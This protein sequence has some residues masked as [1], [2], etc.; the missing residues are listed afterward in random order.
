MGQ[1]ARDVIL[2][3]KGVADLNYKL[4]GPLL[5]LMQRRSNPVRFTIWS[6]VVYFL[7]PYALFAL[8]WRGMRYPAYW[9]RWPERFG[10]ISPMRYEKTM[11]VHAV[12]VGEVRGI[13]EL[14]KSLARKYPSHRILVT[15][16]TPTGSSQV[17]E[18]FGDQVS[19]SYVPYDLPRAV[20]RFMDRVNPDFVV[21]A[22]TEFWPNLFGECRR[23]NIPLLLV[24]VRVSAASIRG[25]RRVPRTSHAMLENAD[26]LCV[27]TKN[28]ARELEDLGVSKRLIHVTGNLKFD[29]PVTER[30]VQ[31]GLC[32]RKS[33]G[34]ERFVLIAAS[35]HRGEESRVLDAFNRLRKEHPEILLILVPRHPERFSAVARLCK[36]A[37]YNVV[38]RSTHKGNLTSD[39]DVLVGD[40]MGELQKLYIA[41]DVAIIGGSLVP[42]GGHNLLEACA[43]GVPVIFGPH[44]FHL[45]ELSAMVIERNA[46][47]QI[48]GTRALVDAVATYL[49]NPLCRKEAGEAARRLVTENSGS[50]RRTLELIDS[51]LKLKLGDVSSNRVI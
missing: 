10:Y 23:R 25:Y 6:V 32:I 26:V 17:Q 38:C 19:H 24:N 3:N 8:L 5:K 7:L 47:C 41:S 27:Q 51:T 46:G 48:D 49:K 11:W 30:L 31:E 22:E 43:V 13:S 44:M 28:D 35:T 16:A 9:Y 4:L 12:S 36:K 40:T 2:K 29:M 21:V 45:N 34:Q 33:W 39:V 15:T 37:G 18:L 14:V 1:C 42:I 20:Q 50:L